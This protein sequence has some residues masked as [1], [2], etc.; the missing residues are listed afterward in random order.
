M[1]LVVGDAAEIRETE[2]VRR[3]LGPFPV[4]DS[5]SWSPISE[6]IEMVRLLLGRLIRTADGQQISS[7]SYIGVLRRSRQPGI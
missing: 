1:V 4:P 2:S 7:F 6:V 3:V 5:I